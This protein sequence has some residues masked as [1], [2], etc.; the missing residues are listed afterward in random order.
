MISVLE[1]ILN[2]NG[3]VSFLLF[4]GVIQIPTAKGWS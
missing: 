4:E 2:L 3:V 1:S